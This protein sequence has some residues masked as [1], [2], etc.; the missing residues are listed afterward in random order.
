MTFDTSWRYRCTECGCTTLKKRVLVE[1]PTHKGGR[2]ADGRYY[3]KGCNGS[4]DAVTD[5]KTGEVATP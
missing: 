5:M 3:C 1:G 2:T 4:H